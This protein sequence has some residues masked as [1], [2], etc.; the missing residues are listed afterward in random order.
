MKIDTLAFVNVML[1]SHNPTVFH[2]HINV[3]VPVS[4]HAR[5]PHHPQVKLIISYQMFF[6]V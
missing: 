6:L 2:P 1:S 3:L 4:T 5:H